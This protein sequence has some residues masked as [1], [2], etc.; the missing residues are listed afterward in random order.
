[1]GTMLVINNINFLLTRISVLLIS[2][3]GMEKLARGLGV[4]EDPEKV[5]IQAR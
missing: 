2:R 3:N 1:M 5:D 4:A